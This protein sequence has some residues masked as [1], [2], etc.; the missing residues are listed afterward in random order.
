[1]DLSKADWTM[2]GIGAGG[3]LAGLLGASLFMKGKP[4]DTGLSR[5]YRIKGLTKTDVVF[6][7]KAIGGGYYL[8]FDA[9][10][11][12]FWKDEPEEDTMDSAEVLA[13]EVEAPSPFDSPE[14]AAAIADESMAARGYTPVD[15]WLDS[16]EHDLKENPA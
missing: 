14:D 6:H 5:L 10:Y 15:G 8:E 16:L 2:I 11:G 13:Q 1:M 4:T 7:I 9:P 3:V 12:V